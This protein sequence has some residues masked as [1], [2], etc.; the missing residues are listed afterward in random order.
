MRAYMKVNTFVLIII[1]F[2]SCKSNLFYFD[3]KKQ[4]IIAVDT[5]F[6]NIEINDLCNNESYVLN[7]TIGGEKKRKINL[8]YIPE[9][10][11]IINVKTSDTI[12]IFTFKNECEY[13]VVNRGLYD[14]KERKIM[15]KMDSLGLFHVVGK[16]Q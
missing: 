7:R 10:Y 3:D 13:E 2:I 4:E 15:L 14:A 9:S 1:L 8:N 5:Y 6:G 16:S 12:Q 11:Q